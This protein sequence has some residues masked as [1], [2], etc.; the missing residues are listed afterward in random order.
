M[1]KI[2]FTLY[3]LLGVVCGANAATYTVEQVP[4]VHVTDRNQFVSNPDNILSPAAVATL[5]RTI[6]GVWDSTS[7][8]M[9]VVAIDDIT[10][11]EVNQ[12]AT[13]LFEEW[14][15][16]KKDTDNG[17]LILIVKDIHR[18]VIRTGRGIEGALP[19]VICGRIIRDVVAP[20]FRRNNYDAGTIK[21]VDVMSAAIVNPQ[22][23]AELKS[24]FANDARQP[25]SLSDFSLDS[26]FGLMTKIGALATLILL[27]AIIWLTLFGD[28]NAHQER[29]RKLNTLKPIALFMCF[30]GLGIP[31]IAYIPLIIAMK[32]IRNHRRSCPN[33]GTRMKKLD[34]QTDNLYLTPAQ[35]T[36]ERLNSI[37]YDVWLC[38]DCGETDIIPY[39]NHSS[40]YTECP[41]CHAHACTLTSDRIVVKPTTTRN[42]QRVKTYT[43]LNCQNKTH[44]NITLP[45]EVITPIIIGGIGGNGGGGGGFSGGSFGGGMTSGGGASGGW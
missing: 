5:N 1:K 35:D 14:G 19:D 20:E 36:E 27:G 25:I 18:I 21:A 2:L 11:Y 6:A 4:N 29:Y 22:V 26:I 8:E 44:R 30:F 28:K 34:E 15:I 9:V 7:V 13:K 39:I 43:C 23:V 42:G 41:V 10:G 3:I 32:R 40:A 33:C 16:G 12:F 24:K 45:K 31:L 17:L 37:D 38:P